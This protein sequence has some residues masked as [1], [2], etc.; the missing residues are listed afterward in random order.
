[1]PDF[2]IAPDPQPTARDATRE[3]IIDMIQQMARLARQTG[4]TRIAIHLDAILAAEC[5]TR[6][7][8]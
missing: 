7:A 2:T 1:M 4:E 6:R 5:D 3:Y 8:G